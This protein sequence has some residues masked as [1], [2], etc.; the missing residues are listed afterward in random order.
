MRTEKLGVDTPTPRTDLDKPR[1]GASRCAR[2]VVGNVPYG[3]ASG[4]I[5]L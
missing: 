4:R 1:R 3:N 2:D 5:G